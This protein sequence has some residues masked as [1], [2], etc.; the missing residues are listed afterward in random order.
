VPA[1]TLQRVNVA[2]AFVTAPR[3][4]VLDEPTS[5]LAPVDRAGLI[6]VLRRLQAETGVSFLFISHDL[7]T[8]ASL[9]HRVVVMY[10]GQIVEVGPTRRLF[11]APRH[12]YTR[13]LVDAYLDP[14]AEVPRAV[15]SPPAAL[16]GEIPSPIDLPPGCFLASRCA[17]AVDRCRTERQSLL[18]LTS[19]HSVRCWRAAELP[20]ARSVED[21]A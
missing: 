5:L 17:W 2:R 6:D 1:G 10:L 13:A 15:R 20:M 4:V 16:A 18:A 9:C 19:D 3:F 11:D 12:P 7:A 14:A 8:V 21:P